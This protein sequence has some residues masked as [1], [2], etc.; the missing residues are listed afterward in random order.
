MQALYLLGA[1]QVSSLS[2]ELQRF[3]QADEPSLTTDS[4]EARAAM[5][6]QIVA[7]LASFNRT[8]DDFEEMARKELIQEKRE[9]AE[10]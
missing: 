10:G 1:R 3:E 8:I 7:S 5:N 6:G 9:K 4:Q 2:T